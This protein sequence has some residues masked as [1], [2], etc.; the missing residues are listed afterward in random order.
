MKATSLDAGL[1]G[2][3]LRVLLSA[4][5]AFGAVPVRALAE[6]VDVAEDET[7]TVV[8]VVD[9][10]AEDDSADLQPA[11]D[12]ASGGVAEGVS[13]DLGGTAEDGG[14]LV[15]PA[16]DDKASGADAT[17]TSED[18]ELIDDA[19][20][21]VGAVDVEAFDSEEVVDGEV[22]AD[23]AAAVDEPAEEAVEPATPATQSEEEPSSLTAQATK[24]YSISKAKVASIGAKRWTSK[25]ITPKPTVKYGNKTLKLG[26]DYTLSYKNNV[27]PGT[28]TI[29][30]TG[31]G[32]YTGS[33]RVTF[34]IKKVGTWKHYS[35]GWRYVY[36]KGVYAKS[37]FVKIDG[38]VYRFDKDGIMLTG[39]RRL[40][41][42]GRWWWYYFGSD[43]ARRTGWQ[44]VG[45]EWYWLDRY[46]RMATGLKSIGGSKYY[47]GGDGAMRTGWQKISKKWYYFYGSGAMAKSCWVGDYY[48]GKSGA[49]LTNTIT[50]D[51]YRVLSSGRWDG[52]GKVA[53]KV[54]TA[55]FSVAIPSYWLGK[56][57]TS[58]RTSGVWTIETISCS[59]GMLVEFYVAKNSEYEK[60]DL[61]GGVWRVATKKGSSYTVDVYMAYP[62]TWDP[63]IF[64]YL[65]ETTQA[66]EGA[67]IRMLTAGKYKTP[68]DASVKYAQ[69]YVEKNIVNKL[70]VK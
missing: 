8:E 35:A 28:A 66:R 11:N 62:E 51:G 33:K 39:W 4:S 60:L 69:E 21:G 20:M 54:S 48:V 55:A 32:S 65:D 7:E 3:G 67:S 45:G 53:T 57:S 22:V 42:D 47:L 2:I 12:D 5:L 56:V 46:G 29:T 19:Q 61:R 43:G 26:R 13:D 30:I 17:V 41:A 70:V 24:T 64:P 68:S 63:G 16:A 31:K 58:S 27:K 18:G 10:A 52:K 37:Q 9:E 25:A 34:A 40:K 36:A 23:E 50:P 49:M 38:K 15:G 14:G 59:N 6:A 44:S 1:L